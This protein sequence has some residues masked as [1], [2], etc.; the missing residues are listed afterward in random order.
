MCLHVFTHTYIHTYIQ[1]D[2]QTYIHT[3]IHTY[4]GDPITERQRMIVLS[5]GSFVK[6]G[7]YSDARPILVA[8]STLGSI[9]PNTGAH[10]FE[11]DVVWEIPWVTVTDISRRNFDAWHHAGCRNAWN[12]AARSTAVQRETAMLLNCNWWITQVYPIRN[13]ND[14]I[15]CIKTQHAQNV[16]FSTSTSSGKNRRWP[17]NSPKVCKIWWIKQLQR[18]NM[19]WLDE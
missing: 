19:G 15:M 8:A 5:K 11:N 4:P 2:R 9:V 13:L 18:P 10:K 6:G 12:P 17:C 14:K 3:Y 1:T 7:G 16:A